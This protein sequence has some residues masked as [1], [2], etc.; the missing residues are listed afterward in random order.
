MAAALTGR[1]IEKYWGERYYK[2]VFL[3]FCWKFFIFI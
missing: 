3:G 1:S 2:I